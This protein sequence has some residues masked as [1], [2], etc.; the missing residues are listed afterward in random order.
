MVRTLAACLL[1]ALATPALADDDSFFAIG[2]DWAGDTKL[3]RPYGI[4]VDVF[5]L[6]Q[7]YGVD[8][9][10]FTLPGVSL[11]DP[12]E[13]DVQNRINHEDLK[14]DVWVLPF[15]NVFGVWGHVHARTFVD[16][17]AAQGAPFPL[18]KLKVAYS[19]Q[20]YGG[21]FTAIYGGE[22]WFA[23]VTGTFTDTD[24]TGDFDSNVQSTTWQPRVGWVQGPW[25][26]WVGA[27]YLDITERHEGAIAIPVLGNVPFEVELSQTEDWS[28]AL[29]MHYYFNDAIE[30]SLEVGK[31]NDRTTTLLNIGYR[32]D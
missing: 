24:L 1:L 16:L 13:L 11:D 18:G 23:S 32:F 29:G 17:S 22:H 19:G 5:T 20:V 15:L 21:G 3:P 8:K 12:S 6:D 7:P 30:A 28:P 10:Q 4:S 2:R 26:L 31:G 14:F 25:S 27:Y 9:L